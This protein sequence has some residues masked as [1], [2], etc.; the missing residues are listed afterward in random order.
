VY[1]RQYQSYAKSFQEQGIGVKNW[2]IKLLNVNSTGPLVVK[3]NWELTNYTKYSNGIYTYT[4]D[5]TLGLNNIPSLNRLGAG[6]NQ[7]VTTRITLP[8]GAKF[9]QIPGDINIEANGSRVTMKVERTS[10]REIVIRSN[11]YLRYGMKSDDYSAMMEKVP[12]KLEFQ[13]T[14]GS[15]KSGVCGPAVILGLAVLPLL[16]RKRR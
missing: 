7:T 1:K 11:V 2:N 4:Y 8:E 16:L 13:Y 12:T 5:P 10:D 14:M 9:T 3:M 15:E 6:V